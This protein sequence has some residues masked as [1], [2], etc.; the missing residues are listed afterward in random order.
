MPLEPFPPPV[1]EGAVEDAGPGLLAEPHQK[2]HVV[3]RD[4]AQPEHVLDHEQ[5]PEVTPRDRGTGLAVALRI[6]RLGGPLERGAPYVDSAG[7]QPRRTVPP[8]PGGGDAVEEI[9][10]ARDPL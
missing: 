5:M 8:V 6:E 10:S 1:I 7:G 4:Q 3:D 2:P 9:Y